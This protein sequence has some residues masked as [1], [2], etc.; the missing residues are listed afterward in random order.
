MLRSIKAP[1]RMDSS[2][3]PKCSW[4]PA[5]FDWKSYKR[6]ISHEINGPLFP[7]RSWMSWEQLLF[8]HLRFSSVQLLSRVWLFATPWAAA[9]QASLSITNFWSLLKLMY[10][11][12]E[13]PSNHLIPFS[14]C[15]WSCVRSFPVS[16]F[17]VSGGQ[18]I[19]VSASASVLPMN[20]QD[21]FPLGLT[22]LISCSPRDSQESSPTPQFRSINSSTLSFLYGVCVCVNVHTAF[23]QGIE[24]HLVIHYFALSW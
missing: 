13:M 15:L 2:L 8:L 1:K 14:S 3:N 21:W 23:Q 18:D 24:R 12:L 16:Q 17:F 6:M 11:E 10:M 4:N 19:G 22:D 5:D 9:C 7:I 20:I